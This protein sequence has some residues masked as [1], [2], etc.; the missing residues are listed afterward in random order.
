[1]IET[2]GF[3]SCGLKA[4]CGK[5]AHM[6][7]PTFFISLCLTQHEVVAPP[8]KKQNLCFKSGPHIILSLYKRT[9]EITACPD[10]RMNLWGPSLGL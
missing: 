4:P 7:W 5:M 6:K 9:Q 10:L 1:M 8:T 2:Q 3:L